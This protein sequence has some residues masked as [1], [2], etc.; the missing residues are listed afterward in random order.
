MME[1]YCELYLEE[2][3]ADRKEKI[4]KRLQ[5]GK[6]VPGCYVISLAQREEEYLEIYSAVELVQKYYREKE[7]LVVGLAKS[8]EGAFE[9]IEQLTNKVYEETKDADLKAYI[10]R[11]QENKDGERM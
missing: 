4:C 11:K 9:I 8:Q 10:R 6:M 3:L 7:I 5:K 2:G 1:I